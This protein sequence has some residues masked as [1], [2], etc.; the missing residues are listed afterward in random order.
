[1]FY[2]NSEP[3]TLSDLEAALEGTSFS[4]PRSRLRLFSDVILEV[5]LRQ[6]SADKLTA[7]L[8]AVKHV[9]LSESQR[10]DNVL[11]VT[12]A[13]P[14]SPLFGRE[15]ADF[16]KNP[17]SKE[18]FSTKSE[19]AVKADELPSYDAL[20]QVVERHGA[21]LKGL[22]WNCWGCQVHGCVATGGASGQRR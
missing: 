18:R 6:A 5:D 20:R 22:R 14:R 17:L 7:A 16:G 1:M 11:L 15:T 10:K 8:A 21:S 9:S 12:L 2:F 4:V 13:M 19:P 3:I